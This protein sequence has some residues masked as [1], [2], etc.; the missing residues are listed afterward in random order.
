MQIELLLK[1]EGG[2]L[3][4]IDGVNYFFTPD[5]SGR[6]VAE[7]TNQSHI[8]RFLS[9]VGYIEVVITKVKKSK[10]TNDLPMIETSSDEPPAA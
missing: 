5:S 9:I 7:V 1:R 10:I 6:H 3:I 4:D 2:S 8:D